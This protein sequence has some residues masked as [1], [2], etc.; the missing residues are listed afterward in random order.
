M[1]HAPSLRS[2]SAAECRCPAHHQL[3]RLQGN[4]GGALTEGCGSILTCGHRKSRRWNR[5]HGH[6]ESGP[7]RKPVGHVTGTR[8]N[9]V[10]QR[11]RKH[12]RI[13]LMNCDYE[14]G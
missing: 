13:K 12:N 1:S 2:F 7:G 14:S 10:P 6:L 11:R 8:S 9:Q 3:P 4:S 5:E